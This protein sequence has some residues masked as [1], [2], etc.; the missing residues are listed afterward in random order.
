MAY[1]NASNVP[2]GWNYGRVDSAGLVQAGRQRIN[3]APG[4]PRPYLRVA[5]VFD[6]R[7]AASDLNYMPFTDEEFER[8]RL[9]PG[10]I[11]LNEGQSLELVG[12]TSMYRGD[13]PDCAFQNSLIR[14]RAYPHTYA[15]FAEQLFRHL[16]QV[17]AFVSIATK[18]TSI[19]HLGVS[20]FAELKVHFPPLAE[21]RKI[22]AILSS[23]DEAIE[24]TQAVIDQLGI[25][26]K[27]MTVELLT[28][29]LPGRHTKFKLTEIGEVPEAWRVAAVSEIAARSPFA[30]VGGPFG[31]DLTSK[32]YQPSGVPVIRGTNLGGE[33]RW[34]RE[35]G[36]V[37]VA[38]EKAE[39]LRRNLAFP[40]DVIFTQRGTLGQVARVSPQSSHRRFLLSQ[41]QMKLTVNEAVADPDYVVS[42][43]ASPL[44]QDTVARAT[45]ATGIPHIN[46]GLLRAFQLPLP[47]VSEQRE[48]VG[49]IVSLDD[50]IMGEADRG[51]SLSSLKSALMSVLLTGDLRVKPDEDAP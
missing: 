32:H 28:R 17:G 49:L 50:R 34:L 51:R 36:F 37:Y 13:P 41:S 7:I 14:F 3:D 19:A 46:L 4:T 2:H 21:Q 12:R 20:R 48:I 45:V 16:Q 6:G 31:S 18:T 44:G 11:L 23:V 8:F 30:C 10:D 43:F 24:A 5:N 42:F 29:G 9:A 33:S 22:A 47:P 15:P 1:D 27:A 38:E 25:V 35:Y 39:D 26:K 40:G